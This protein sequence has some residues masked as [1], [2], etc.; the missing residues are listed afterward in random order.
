MENRQRLLG[1]LA[2]RGLKTAVGFYPATTRNSLLCGIVVA[3]ADA[4]LTYTLFAHFL[5]P[6]QGDA[7]TPLIATPFTCAGG[8]DQIVSLTATS[9]ANAA[10]TVDVAVLGNVDG[11]QPLA[12]WFYNS[13]A[14]TATGETDAFDGTTAVTIDSTAA[15][16][17]YTFNLGAKGSQLIIADPAAGNNLWRCVIG[18][19]GAF[20][21]LVEFDPLNQ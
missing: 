14:G 20:L 18:A 19:G 3:T 13:G 12:A 15:V 1:F 6:D 2:F 9:D 7:K 11:I 4:A 17:E 10:Q 8:N 21:H 5:V 16:A